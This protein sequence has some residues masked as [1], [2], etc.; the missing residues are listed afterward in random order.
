MGNQIKN[1]LV[2][3][4]KYSDKIMSEIC[5]TLSAH[6]FKFKLSDSTGE[7]VVQSDELSIINEIIRDEV[8]IPLSA[9]N[10]LIDTYL[11]QSKVY[12]RLKFK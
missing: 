10:I 8:K 4:K 6:D 12:I 1:T 9:K 2:E 7:I 3:C 5:D 11:T